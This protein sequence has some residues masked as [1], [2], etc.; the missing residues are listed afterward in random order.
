[1]GAESGQGSDWAGGHRAERGMCSGMQVCM[2]ACVQYSTHSCI[3]VYIF[4]CTYACLYT[5]MRMGELVCSG[6]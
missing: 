4:M 1:M 6:L 3:P 2:C 5:Y